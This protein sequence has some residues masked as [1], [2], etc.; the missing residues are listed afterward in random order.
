MDEEEGRLE[1]GE[2][3]GMDD[4]K[5]GEPEGERRERGRHERERREGG[6]RKSDNQA[7]GQALDATDWVGSIDG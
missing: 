7:L 6:E 1:K 5:E 4:R 2:K 3:P